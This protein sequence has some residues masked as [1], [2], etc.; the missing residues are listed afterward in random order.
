[1]RS[2]KR[3]LDG[4][5]LLDKPSGPSSN[6]ALQQVK[7]LYRAD[8]AGHTGSLDPLASGLLPICFGE[9]TKLSSYL[10]TGDKGYRA[11]AR[12]G[13]RTDTLDAEG[14]LL[15]EAH[16]DEVD[17]SRIEAA[18]VGFRG[19]ISQIPPMYSALK[20]GG[21]TLYAL[22]RQGLEVER[23]PR[24][25]HIARLQLVDYTPPFVVLDVDCSSG[26]YIRTLVDDI[27]QVLGCGAHVHALRR[28][29]AEPF[30]EP[31]MVEMARLEALNGQFTALDSLLLPLES[32]VA[33]L[34]RAT[35][36]GPD[37]LRFAHGNPVRHENAP[38][39][40][41]IAVH[42]PQGQLLGIAR[43]ADGETLKAVRVLN[44]QTS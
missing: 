15:A 35:I 13:Q 43:C 25:V 17:A 37:L 30:R 8:K 24:Q 34:P 4:V 7:L 32:M 2:R 19:N 12:L 41:A 28:T 23:E 21:E 29:W 1:M 18:L 40:Q 6:A 9:A 5:L 33:A 14:R 36:A 22:A 16:F 20:R 42:D 39:A 26:T 3:R 11:I 31:E 27:G 38:M 10:L 44:R